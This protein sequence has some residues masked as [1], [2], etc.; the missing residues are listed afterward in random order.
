[1]FC[2]SLSGNK[3]QALKKVSVGPLDASRVPLCVPRMLRPVVPDL[4][5]AV[6]GAEKRELRDALPFSRSDGPERVNTELAGGQTSWIPT[7]YGKSSTANYLLN[8]AEP[9]LENYR[10]MPEKL[11]FQK[12]KECSQV[13]STRVQS[14][15]GVQWCGT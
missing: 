2:N 10:P 4:G 6:R 5:R 1:M 9:S 7:S 8:I 12:D 14:S 3:H 13:L 15:G 11:D